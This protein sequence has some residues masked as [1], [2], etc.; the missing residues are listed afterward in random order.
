MQA[1]VKHTIVTPCLA[2]S[3]KPPHWLL[4]GGTGGKASLVAGPA[5]PPPSAYRGIFP[6]AQQLC[7]GSVLTCVYPS[8]LAASAPNHELVKGT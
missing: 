3:Q 8:P 6:A 4:P 5:P 2:C 7:V 1:T